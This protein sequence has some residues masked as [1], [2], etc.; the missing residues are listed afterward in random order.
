MAEDQVRARW[1]R[2]GDGWRS[3]ADEIRDF[4]MP[5]SSAMIE[6]LDLQPGQTVLELAAGPGDTGF[7]AAELV[8]PGGRL[9]SS[10]AVEQMLEI[11]RERAAAQSI[12]NVEFKQLELEWIDLETASVDALLVRWG[13][14]FVNDLESAAHELRRVLRP[15]GTGAIAVWDLPEKN[16]WATIPTRALIELGHVEP[17]DPEAP[18]MFILAPPGRLGELL[19][20]AGFVDVDVGTVEVSRSSPGA[21]AY[22][23]ET[24]DLSRPFAEV[25]A[26]LSEAERAAVTAK[27]GELSRP[28]A[29]EQ[30]GFTF[31]GSSLIAA[32]SA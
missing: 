4:G 31:P 22:V 14:M 28:F 10:D 13:L 8:A 7:L 11:G 30:G 20:S 15:G 27:V 3:R 16:P 24:A 26:R 29:D 23:E 12:D 17:P 6:Q 5:V 19:E 25:W 1:Q 21:E 18:G 9:I 2:S 32:A